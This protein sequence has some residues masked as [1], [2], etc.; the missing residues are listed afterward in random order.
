MVNLDLIHFAA[1]I[2]IKVN[3]IIIPKEDKTYGG[4][5]G[6]ETNTGYHR[7]EVTPLF[8]VFT[9]HGK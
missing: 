9:T 7:K 1:P 2:Q 5:H 8:T 4:T 6:K 3:Y